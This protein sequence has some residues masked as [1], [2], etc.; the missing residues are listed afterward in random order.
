MTNTLLDCNAI[1]VDLSKLI[2]ARKTQ[3]MLCDPKVLKEF[4]HLNGVKLK[5]SK[6]KETIKRPTIKNLESIE[7]LE[8]WK[9][10]NKKKL[11]RE[12]VTRKEY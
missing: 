3:K 8:V 7:L 5:N 10:I 11:A 1:Y 6:Q 4:V 9:I 2:K 12:M